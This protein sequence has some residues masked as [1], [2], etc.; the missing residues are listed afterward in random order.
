[1]G[2]FL[3]CAAEDFYTDC[4]NNNYSEGRVD[5]VAWVKRG[6]WDFGTLNAA[7]IAS[8]TLWQ[9]LVANGLAFIIPDVR[10]SYDG[11]VSVETA[12]YGRQATRLAGRNHQ[13][14][15]SHLF[16]WAGNDNTSNFVNNV[17]FYNWLNRQSDWE[18]YF[19]TQHHIWRVG[20]PAMS[21]TALPIS[22]DIAT[23]VEYA[24]TVK[25]AKASLPTPYLLCNGSPNPTCLD[26]FRRCEL[27]DP[28]SDCWNP[29]TIDPLNCTQP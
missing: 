1:M 3:D 21:F 13:V 10:G 25:W 24:V 15:Y 17:E 19:T 20:A 11:S 6:T 2:S 12:G 4:C 27:L 7:N 29:D 8:N 18:F 23:S 14:T 28:T 5:G 26:I 22:E 9:G 16:T